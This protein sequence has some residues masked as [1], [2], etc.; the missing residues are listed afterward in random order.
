MLILRF[1]LRGRLDVLAERL[2]SAG[3]TVVWDEVLSGTRPLRRGSVA[4]RIELLSA[5]E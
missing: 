5:G 2:S 3:A 1:A 4:N